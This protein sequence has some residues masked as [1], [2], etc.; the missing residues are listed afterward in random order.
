VLNKCWHAGM[1]NDNER[2]RT[3]PQQCSCP[4]LERSAF[5]AMRGL[6]PC[7]AAVRG[8]RTRRCRVLCMVVSDAGLLLTDG[9]NRAGAACVL[10][11][12][13]TCHSK[14]HSVPGNMVGLCTLPESYSRHACHLGDVIPL[15]LT[16]NEHTRRTR[17]RSQLQKPVL[18]MSSLKRVVR[19]A[20]MITSVAVL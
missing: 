15:I 6:D 20:V 16:L 14:A 2:R 7:A 11:C 10:H 19:V 9:V 13:S 3:A 17:Y 4:D 1:I 18:S 5:C 8:C 12:T